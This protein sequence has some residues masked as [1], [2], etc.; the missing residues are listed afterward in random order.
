MAERPESNSSQRS[1]RPLSWKF[2]IPLTITLLPMIV[3]PIIW[4]VRSSPLRKD[5]TIATSARGGRHYPIAMSLIDELNKLERQGHVNGVETDGSL[6]NLR[7]LQFGLVDF[8]LYQSGTDALVRRDEFE[9]LDGALSGTNG[10]EA[11]GN[12]NL[13]EFSAG[14]WAGWMSESGISIDAVFR[15]LDSNQDQRLTMLELDNTDSIRCVANLYGEAMH[16][17]VRNDAGI[18]SLHDLVGKRVA[19]GRS[20]SGDFATSKL[21]LEHCEI[22]LDEIDRFEGDTIE[23]HDRGAVELDYYELIFEAFEESELDCA[24]LTVGLH[25]DNVV[26]LLHGL[27]DQVRLVPIPFVDGMIT[28]DVRLTHRVIPAGTY[29]GLEEDIDTISLKAQLLTHTDVDPFIVSQVTA[30]ILSSRFQKMNGLAEL[31]RLDSQDRVEYARGKPDYTIHPAADDIYRGSEFDI[32]QFQNWEAIY[33]LIASIS[34]GMFFAGRWFIHRQN[35]V[36]DRR[37]IEEMRAQK[38]LL[39]SYLE[40]TMAIE[41]RQMDEVNPQQLTEFLDQVTAIKLEALDELTHED[42]RGD[43]AFSIFLMQ[44]ANLIGK[45]QIKLLIH[46][47]RSTEEA[48]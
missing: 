5:V 8:A 20:S 14:A 31:Y 47:Q 38:D 19:L 23:L 30:T 9:M 46:H 33:S 22:G 36:L 1:N 15:R 6:E 27:G 25:A 35:Q 40:R 29:R 12:L 16:V 11:D 3:G 4:Y 37:R 26:H 10:E 7:L 28:K 39:D 13:E 41:R 32:E 43:R 44:C 18:E 48:E 17:I 24:C 2:V 34:L 42:L 21:L 45:I